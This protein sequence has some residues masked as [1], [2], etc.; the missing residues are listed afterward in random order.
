[1]T[2]YECVQ[3][4]RVNNIYGGQDCDRWIEVKNHE[5]QSQ[6]LLPSL[7]IAQANEIALYCCLLIVLAWG[8][9]LIGKLI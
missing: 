6:P 4:E 1:M 5:H 2:I 8:F 7:T 9:R 3:L